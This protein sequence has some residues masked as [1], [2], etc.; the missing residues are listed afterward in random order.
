MSL[1]EAG[2]AGRAHN[3][4]GQ[5]TLGVCDVGAEDLIV[6]CLEGVAQHGV[7]AM[8]LSKTCCLL[9]ETPRDGRYAHARKKHFF[10]Y[11]A[12]AYA[13]F[14]REELLKVTTSK[15]STDPTI[16]HVCG[17]RHCLAAH[18]LLLEPKRV[19]DE[20]VHCHFFLGRVPDGSERHD[21][22]DRHCPHLPPCYS[23]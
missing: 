12:V 15:L 8:K 2:P 13:K 14:G 16:S 7:E 10:I 18:H 4:S 11:Q 20:R 5:H 19:N 21:L 3:K 17:T 9:Q 6:R 22:A 23:V 1:P